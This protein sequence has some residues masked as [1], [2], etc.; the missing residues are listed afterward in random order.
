[1]MLVEEELA[2]ISPKQDMLLTIGVFDGV[3]LG[4]K[5]LLAQL[6]RQAR[7]Q[8]LLSGVVTFR[9]HPQ[10]ILAPHIKLPFLTDFARRIELLK[11]ESIDIVIPLTFSSEL[12]DIGA[13]QFI[14]LLVKYAKM[15]GLVIGPDFALGQ[16]REGHNTYLRQLGQ[17]MNFSVTVTLPY[18]LDGEIISSTAIRKALAKGNMSR[19][20]R[21]IGRPFSIRG[22]VITGSGR[23]TRLG[24]PTANLDVDPEQ[25]LPKEGVYA[26]RTHLNNKTLASVTNIGQRPTFGNSQRTIETHIPDYQDNLYGQELRIDFVE[27]LRDERQFNTEQ[28]LQQQLIQD[29]RQGIAILNS[30]GQKLIRVR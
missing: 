15:R 30:P 22:Q 5:Q 17:E 11:A 12:A 4:H 9:Q 27:R 18:R 21:L 13:R 2:R 3:H 7:Q 16:S 28:E 20:N 29:V 14:S 26:T 6:T 24:F 25:A 23:G 19:A 10:T 1:M 8:D